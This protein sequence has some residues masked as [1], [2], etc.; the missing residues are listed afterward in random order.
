VI[1]TFRHKAWDIR[2][3][4]WTRAGLD[5]GGPQPRLDCLGEPWQNLHRLP[6][7]RSAWLWLILVRALFLY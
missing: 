3:R 1:L 7:M 4:P 5:A 6:S 2:R